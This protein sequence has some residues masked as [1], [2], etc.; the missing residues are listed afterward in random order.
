MKSIIQKRENPIYQ[1]EQNPKTGKFLTSYILNNWHFNL[2]V[3][4]VSNE[5]I[6]KMGVFF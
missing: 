3:Q 6:N 2:F 4:T 5:M 1:R